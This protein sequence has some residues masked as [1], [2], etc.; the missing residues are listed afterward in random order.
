MVLHCLVALISCPDL[1]EVSM[2]HVAINLYGLPPMRH[3]IV[4][5]VDMIFGERTILS[6]LIGLDGNLL[7]I[8]FEGFVCAGDGVMVYKLHMRPRRPRSS[9]SSL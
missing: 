6:S 1:L 7:Q 2:K 3:C 4:E 8:P 9:T 5:Y